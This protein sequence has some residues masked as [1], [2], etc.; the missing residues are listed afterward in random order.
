MNEN[1]CAISTALGVGAISIVRSSGPDVIKIV[2]KIFQGEDLESVN[3]HTLNYGFIVDKDEKIDEVLVSV[4]RAPNTFTREDVVE[5]NC[6]GGITTTNRVLELLLMNGCRLAEPGEFSKKAFLNGRIDLIEAE[7]INDLILSESE[8]ARKYAINRVEGNLSKLIIDQRDILLGLSAELE[9]NFDFPEEM[10][11]PE[12]TH[13]NLHS[14]LTKIKDNLND[15]LKHS[16]EGQIIK[17]GIDVAIVGKPNVGK[18]SILNHLLDQNKAIVT[19]I[20]GTTRDIV[21]GSITLNGIKI[22]LIDTAGIRD[23]EDIVEKIGVDK[24]KEILSQADLAIYVLNNNEDIDDDESAFLKS[25]NTVQKIVFI[26]KDDLDSKIDTK[27]LETSNIVYGNTITHNG[28]NSLKE[29]IIEMFNLN[30]IKSK[31]YNF[32]SNAREIALV[33]T[34]L[35]SIENALKSVEDEMPLEMISVDIKKA[36]DDLGE[37]IGATYKDE[38]LDELFSKFCLGK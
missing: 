38:L 29:K 8:E 24:S 28:L 14:E 25:L 17:N 33:R 22:N 32:L 26:N 9:V 37:I 15:L 10:D 35:E 18:S 11:N 4:M 13:N 7:G 2:K 6:H 16:K 36:Y 30:E 34:A 31:N 1:I 5:I 21:E 12:V 23:T 27:K 19:D 20:A 3:T